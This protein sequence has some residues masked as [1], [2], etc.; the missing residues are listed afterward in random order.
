MHFIFRHSLSFLV[1]IFLLS[2]QAA[3][4]PTLVAPEGS[5]ANPTEKFWSLNTKPE[6]GDVAL[7]WTFREGSTL[8]IVCPSL[9]G[10]GPA[11]LVVSR[12]VVHL[13]WD[14]WKVDRATLDFLRVDRDEVIGY[15]HF[16]PVPG[17]GWL[18]SDMGGKGAEV[19][20]AL[21]AGSQLQS[22]SRTKSPES[23][24]IPLSGMKALLGDF[25]NACSS[26][27]ATPGHD[28]LPPYQTTG[29]VKISDL[30]AGAAK[31]H[32]DWGQL[33]G[34]NHGGRGLRN[35]VHEV[36]TRPA[37]REC[38]GL[39]LI[40]SVYDFDIYD[41]A[42]G[43]ESDFT[44]LNVFDP[45]SGRPRDVKLGLSQGECATG[46]RLPVWQRLNRATGE[47]QIRVFPG[48]EISTA[49]LTDIIA[50][51]DSY[52]GDPDRFEDD[53][54][55]RLRTGHESTPTRPGSPALEDW[56]I[57]FGYEL[58]DGSA[59][60]GRALPTNGPA[61][62][63]AP[64]ELPD[65]C[66]QSPGITQVGGLPVD[67]AD[68]VE[69]VYTGIVLGQPRLFISCGDVRVAPAA[70]LEGQRED[71]SWA[72]VTSASQDFVNSLLER[73]LLAHDQRLGFEIS[74]LDTGGVSIRS[75][76]SKKP[77]DMKA[78]IR[79]Y[80]RSRFL[81][82]ELDVRS[83]STAESTASLMRAVGLQTI[84][85]PVDA[86]EEG[87]ND[88]DVEREARL[89]V[90]SK[91]IEPGWEPQRIIESLPLLLN[92]FL[93]ET[94]ESMVTLEQFMDGGRRLEDQELVEETLSKMVEDG[95]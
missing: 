62:T 29:M 19:L 11:S 89:F 77:W 3:A 26:A 57:G 75:A 15:T 60:L 13:P 52:D 22:A 91:R 58:R 94:T 66:F 82:V 49:Q 88:E 68:A 61:E 65:E 32:P 51:A 54:R 1:S 92:I 2:Q 93:L 30:P 64:Q 74:E 47:A 28:I 90:L 5:I 78:G 85:Q 55:A 73:Y 39:L 80:G 43:A 16:L 31:T 23:W 95:L 6:I 45:E 36:W 35:P 72:I 10:R 79:D 25:R 12:D 59:V 87:A 8:S 53:L 33:T 42:R 41:L 67:D 70:L 38:A 17:T 69:T 76:G 7:T 86:G 46:G 48:E 50:W 71:G 63:L 4:Q 81:V 24:R 21:G 20:E 14:E 9:S 27:A 37:G 18:T 44:S 56:R 40:T 34:Y 83:Q 84:I